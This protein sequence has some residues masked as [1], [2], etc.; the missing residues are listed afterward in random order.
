MGARRGFGRAEL[1][2][3]MLLGCPMRPGASRYLRVLRTDFFTDFFLTSLWTDFFVRLMSKSPLRCCGPKPTMKDTYGWTEYE[4]R[5]SS[6]DLGCDYN[7][8]RWQP[9]PRKAEVAEVHS[10]CDRVE[11]RILK[12]FDP[13]A[14][15]MFDAPEFREDCPVEHPCGRYS[16]SERAL[17]HCEKDI[18]SEF[19]ECVARV[20]GFELPIRR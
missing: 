3:V 2:P 5:C 17:W 14:H 4:A 16:Y 10:R 20:C 18:E 15:E 8:T 19:L 7:A 13:E 6:A 9:A 1:E 11:R 12:D